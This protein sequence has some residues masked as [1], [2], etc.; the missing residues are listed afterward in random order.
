MND[1]HE[2]TMPPVSTISVRWVVLTIALLAI[3]STVGSRWYY[4]AL[5]RRPLALWGSEFA[6]TLVRADRIEAL[7]LKPLATDD[8][9]SGETL[10]VAGRRFVVVMQCEV[11][12][13]PGFSHVRHSWI[14]DRAFDWQAT[15]KPN[16]ID[17]PY[18]LRARR[19]AAT[20][21][22]LIDPESATVQ[23]LDTGVAASMAPVM[24]GIHAL[25]SEALVESP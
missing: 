4:A 23:S 9:A 16:P 1:R 19:G 8:S 20:A 15:V 17:W 25:L 13:R 11:L 22:W 6:A 18:A 2:E 3:V 7:R 24:P 12:D 21:T 14:N 5:Q 10:D